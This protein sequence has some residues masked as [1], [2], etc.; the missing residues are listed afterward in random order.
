M[1]DTKSSAMLF[2]TARTVNEAA[3]FVRKFAEKDGILSTL[4]VK[5]VHFNVEG[6]GG[7]DTLH[8]IFFS[9]PLWKIAKQFWQITGMGISSR[10][11]NMILKR[12]STGAVL[13]ATDTPYKTKWV[14]LTMFQPPCRKFLTFLRIWRQGVRTRNQSSNVESQAWSAA[15]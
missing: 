4:K 15:A 3:T 6:K 10:Y 14:S 7:I 11:A 1:G 2:P 13:V 12:H 5:V 9:P 8:T